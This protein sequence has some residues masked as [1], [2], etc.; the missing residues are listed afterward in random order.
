MIYKK[1]DCKKYAM[2]CKH[3]GK[4]CKNNELIKKSSIYNNWSNNL[5]NL[6][7][8]VGNWLEPKNIKNNIINKVSS[9]LNYYN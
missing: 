4:L 3:N 7:N 8:R 6:K 9:V 1:C 2:L 5:N